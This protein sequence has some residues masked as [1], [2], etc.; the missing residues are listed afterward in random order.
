MSSADN[1]V[2]SSTCLFQLRPAPTTTSCRRRHQRRRR[3]RQVSVLD[4]CLKNNVAMRRGDDEAEMVSFLN[5]LCLFQ[6]RLAPTT[7][8]VVVVE[9]VG[10]RRLI[11]L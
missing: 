8:D 10:S 9:Q 7:T 2:M 3:R 6:L 4:D 1:D 5:M 11:F